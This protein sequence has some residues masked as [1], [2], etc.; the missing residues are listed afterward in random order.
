MLFTACAFASA[1]AFLASFFAILA[2][3]L[4]SL[5][6]V[7]S[8]FVFAF[9]FFLNLSSPFHSTTG[10]LFHEVLFNLMF[11]PTALLPFVLLFYCFLSTSHLHDDN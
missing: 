9:F 3:S 10:F 1:T 8:H 7:K 6:P 4:S 11:F 2:A 5:L